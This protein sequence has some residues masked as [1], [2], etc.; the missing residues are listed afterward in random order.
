MLQEAAWFQSLLADVG[1][2]VETNSTHVLLSAARAG[3]GV[4]VL[5]R[6]VA[7]CH[8]DLVRV[9]NDVANHEVWLITHPEFRRAQS[10]AEAVIPVFPAGPA[11]GVFE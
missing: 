6:F 9:S 2:C 11:R 5:P 8:D 3:I 4:A 7:R 1:A 10:S